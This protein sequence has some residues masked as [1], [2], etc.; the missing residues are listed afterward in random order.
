MRIVAGFVGVASLFVSWGWLGAPLGVEFSGRIALMVALGVSILSVLMGIFWAPKYA[1]PG[2]SPERAEARL[3]TG[4]VAL[5][6]GAATV[7]P[8]FFLLESPVA[9]W[10]NPMLLV[11]CWALTSCGALLLWV[12]FGHPR[13]WS[14]KWR[15]V[16][17]RKSSFVRQ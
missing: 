5:C 12:A 11:F 3:E 17:G 10:K 13:P 14:R 1:I 2:D 4:F 15:H 7:V 16:H 6:F 9:V 8:G